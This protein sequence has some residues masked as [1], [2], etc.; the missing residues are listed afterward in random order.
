[1]M[2]YLGISND[3]SYRNKIKGITKPFN[4]NEPNK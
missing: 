4:I 2:N 3:M 1:M